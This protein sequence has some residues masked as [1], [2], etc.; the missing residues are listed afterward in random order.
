MKNIFVKIVY[1]CVII[2]LGSAVL[3]DYKFK[4]NSFLDWLFKRNP[5][6]YYKGKLI[7]EVEK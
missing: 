2:Y 3:G 7:L 1:F 5:T 6:I 4:Y